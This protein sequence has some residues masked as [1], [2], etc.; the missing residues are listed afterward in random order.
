MPFDSKA[1]SR[2]QPKS[3]RVTRAIKYLLPFSVFGLTSLAFTERGILTWLPILYAFGLIPLL[4]LILKP[5]PGNM[6]R[7][8]EEVVR[9][10]P[11]YDAILYTVVP[12]QYL[13]LWLFLGS[14][15]EVGLSLTDL[16]GRI[17]GMG[18]LCG[19]FGIN[20]AHEL[21]H[22]KNP[23]ERFLAKSL[24]LT[25][26]YM[27]FYIEHNKGH[28]K[29]V[30]TPQ[31][32]STARYRQS[33]YAFWLQ[34][35]FG[36]YLSAW[37]IAMADA[38][39]SDRRFPAVV[40]E[41]ALYQLIQAAAVLIVFLVFGLKA[42]VCFL[43]AGLMGG[44]LLE[45]VNYI[46]HYGLS[47]RPTDAG[48]FERVMPSHSWNSDHVIGRLL[49]FELSRHS[50]HHYMASRKYQVLRHF[51]EAPQMPTGYP[52]MILLALLPPGWFRVMHREIQ[53]QGLS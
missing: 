22:R 6:D 46:E 41:M 24:L 30:A 7:A 20:V 49:L 18:L 28:H 42:T 45:S 32:P 43:V 33:I 23:F 13:S 14:L 2:S 47:R 37:R 12:L 1:Y 40:N 8:E 53:R 48:G 39:K 16:A 44:L 26:L 35:L 17:A 9:K 34:S 38:R 10:D 21:G 19:V 52:G 31:D 50:D 4:E 15:D 36:T 25:S 5:Q 29:H 11:F 51:D 27:H 3:S